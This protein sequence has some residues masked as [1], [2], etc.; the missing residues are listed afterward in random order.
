MS[1]TKKDRFVELTQKAIKKFR[2]KLLDISNRNNLINLNFNPR[3]NKVLRIIDEIPN[4]VFQKLNNNSKLK[5]VPLPPSSDD[6]KDEK[7]PEFK[8]VL[9]E[10]KLVNENYLKDIDE[11]GEDFDIGTFTYINA[12]YGVTIQNNVQIGSHCS[13]YSHSTIDDKQ[14]SVKLMK[15]CRVGTHST[16]MPGVTIGENSIIA[17]YSFVNKNIPENEMWGGIPAK[18]M[19]KLT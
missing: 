14:G 10:E 8:K 11:L 19:K 5:L 15:N 16:I 13:I 4:S 7:T 6:P 9:E 1:E 17:A 18:L 12:K 3:S 2:E